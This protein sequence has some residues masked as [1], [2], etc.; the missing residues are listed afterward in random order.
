[1]ILKIDCFKKVIRLHFPFLQKMA[2]KHFKYSYNGLQV[3]E[4]FKA[5]YWKLK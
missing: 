1:M 4:M 2:E 3:C 5:M